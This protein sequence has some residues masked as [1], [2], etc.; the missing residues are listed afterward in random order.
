MKDQRLNMLDT[1]TFKDR[2]T[3]L[4][5]EVT[6]R[7]NRIDKDIRHEDMSAD[8]SE[9]ATERE[10]DE[11]LESLGIN[12]DQTLLMINNALQRIEAGE[13]FNCSEC[14][15][16]IPAARLELLPFSSLCVDCAEFLE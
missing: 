6:L 5:T 13:Y 10:N 16:S 8:W 2:L 3:A 14:G 7:L 1:Q 4:K 15:E 11:V 9:Q 12:A